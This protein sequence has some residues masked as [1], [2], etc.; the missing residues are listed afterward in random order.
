MQSDV[1]KLNWTD[2][3]Y[4]FDEMSKKSSNALQYAP[5][6]GVGG[7]REYARVRVDEWPGG[8]PRLLI[9]QFIKD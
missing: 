8:S 1:T 4:F 9:G 2:M 6:N 7:L 3:L 5:S